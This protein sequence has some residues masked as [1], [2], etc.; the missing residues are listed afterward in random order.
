MLA[1]LVG[2]GAV[3]GLGAWGYRSVY[4][5]GLT[6]GRAEIA[7]QWSADRLKTQ[8]LIEA[9]T[10]ENAAAE[11]AAAVRAQETDDAYRAV[12]QGTAAVADA[13][14]RSLRDHENRPRANP[15]AMPGDH[16]FAGI[17]DT[18]VVPGPGPI[19]RAVAAR[20]AEC[21]EHEAAFETLRTQLTPQLRK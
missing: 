4:N 1:A 18:T 19:E 14:A 15:S 6:A 17:T 3:A 12:V 11:Q 16:P 20:L 9:K 13:Y 7:T 5:G 10:A 2:I 21:A 8:T